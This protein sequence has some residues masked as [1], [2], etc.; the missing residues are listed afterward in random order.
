MNAVNFGVLSINVALADFRE[1]RGL[2]FFGG[3]E[4][5]VAICS[6]LAAQSIVHV[7]GDSWIAYNNLCLACDVFLTIPLVLLLGVE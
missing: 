5:G 7:I 6:W 4:G 3:V 2:A 1:R